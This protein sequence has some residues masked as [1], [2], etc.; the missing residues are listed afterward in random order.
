MLAPALQWQLNTGSG[1]FNINNDVN[2]SGVNT[3]ALQI[4]GIPGSWYGY[5]FRCLVANGNISD[6]TEIRL[7]NFWTGA[8]DSQWENP[9]NWSCGTVP[10]GNTD[11]II[12][13]GNIIINSNTTI[14]TLTLTIGAQLTVNPPYS[15]IILH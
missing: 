7:R 15:L 12:S 6:T 14:R 1:F 11:V 13:S 10:D 9:A 8:G 3:G 5:K 2:F 4:N